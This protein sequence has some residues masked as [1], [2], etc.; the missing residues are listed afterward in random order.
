MILSEILEGSQIKAD[1]AAICSTKDFVELMP[2]WTQKQKGIE[3][4]TP[5]YASGL[6]FTKAI[7]HIG[8]HS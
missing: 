7:R 3:R 6:A 8:L 5:R 2:M 1:Q 4:T